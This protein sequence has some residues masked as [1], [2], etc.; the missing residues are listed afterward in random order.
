MHV[1]GVDAE[2]ERL[3]VADADFDAG[4]AFAVEEWNFGE[5]FYAG[6]GGG[7]GLGVGGNCGERQENG[8]DKEFG[9]V[10]DGRSSKA[11]GHG[12]SFFARYAFP[13]CVGEA[14]QL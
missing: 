6:V 14:L 1:S 4:C 7:S 5:E 13:V 2:F 9:A 10:S 12:R 8:K 3:A 11:G